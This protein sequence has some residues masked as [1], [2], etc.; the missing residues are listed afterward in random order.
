MELV[1]KVFI[2]SF[3]LPSKLH[4]HILILYKIYILCDLIYSFPTNRLCPSEVQKALFIVLINAF[5]LF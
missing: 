3:P 2:S 1:H 5:Y 4:L